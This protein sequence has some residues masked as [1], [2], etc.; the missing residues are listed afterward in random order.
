MGTAG[1]TPTLGRLEAD[2]RAP[3]DSILRSFNDLRR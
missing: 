3:S 1:S 2:S